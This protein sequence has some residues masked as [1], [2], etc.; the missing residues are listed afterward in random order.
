[1]FPRPVL[2]C[3]A[4][5]LAALLAPLALHVGHGAGRALAGAAVLLALRRWL[6]RSAI[7]VVALPGITAHTNLLPARVRSSALQACTLDVRAV[8]FNAQMAVL[9]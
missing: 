8:R 5:G 4:A 3:Q 2:G 7:V 9:P 1:V 6:R